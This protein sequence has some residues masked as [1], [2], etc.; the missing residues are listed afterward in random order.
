MS[1]KD[2]TALCMRCGD[3]VWHSGVEIKTKRGTR[4]VYHPKCFQV[5]NEERKRAHNA[6]MGAVPV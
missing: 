5:E 3:P 1:S 4:I 2:N 6:K